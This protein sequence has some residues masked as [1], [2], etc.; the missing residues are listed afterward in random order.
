MT[1]TSRGVHMMIGVPPGGLGAQ[2]PAMQAWL[3]R[4]AGAGA[5]ALRAGSGPAGTRAL[6]LDLGNERLARAFVHRWV[7]ARVEFRPA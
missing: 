7:E 4:E 3:D 6:H 5:Y 2:L 1:R